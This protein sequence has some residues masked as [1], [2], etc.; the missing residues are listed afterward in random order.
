MSTG[1]F[2]T[3]PKISSAAEKLVLLDT[4]A[5]KTG[6]TAMIGRGQSGLFDEVR[7]L[8]RPNRLIAAGPPVV[9]LAFLG[10]PDTTNRDLDEER[11][12]SAF[13]PVYTAAIC[14]SAA[15]DDSGAFRQVLL[16]ATSFLTPV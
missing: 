3:L 6:V 4:L 8:L 9:P 15:G 2:A 12:F 7:T 14:N 13:Q 11:C 1:L 16:A 5:W 10:A